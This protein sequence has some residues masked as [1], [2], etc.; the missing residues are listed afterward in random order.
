MGVGNVLPVRWT[1][2]GR[3][4]VRVNGQLLFSKWR[5]RRLPT[6]DEI[7]ELMAAKCG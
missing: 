4:D 2:H 6:E 7:V 3:F 5:A 1:Q